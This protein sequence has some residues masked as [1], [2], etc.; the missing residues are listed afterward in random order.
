MVLSEDG[1]TDQW[2]RIEIPEIDPYKYTQLIFE[3]GIKVI[4][5][6]KDNL[7]SNGAGAVGHP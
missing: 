2:N 6:K 5:C 1:H 3:K 7:F 4:Q